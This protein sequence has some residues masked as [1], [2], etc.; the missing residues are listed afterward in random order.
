MKHLLRPYRSIALAIVAGAG[1]ALLPPGAP[2]QSNGFSQLLEKLDPLLSH[3]SS[4]GYLGVLVSDVDNDTAAKLKLKET[5]GALITLIDHDAP[6]GPV[7][8]I[9][10]VVLEINGQKVEG[11]EQFGRMLREIPAGRKVNLAFSRDG[12]QQTAEVQ[13]VDRKT[14][15]KAVWNSLNNPGATSSKAPAMG[16]LAGGGDLPSTGLRLSV[17]GSSLHVGAMVEPL[18]SQMADYLGIPNG[19]MIKQVARKSEA[20]AAGLKEHDV[21]LKVGTDAIT[22][23]ADWDR[24]LRASEGKQVPVTILRDR[25][26][27]TVMLQVDSKHKSEVE[28]EKAWPGLLPDGPAPLLAQVFGPDFGTDAAGILQSQDFQQELRID[29]RQMEQFRQDAEKLRDSMKSWNLPPIDQK[30]MDEFRKQMDQ[31][32]Q[33]F[34]ADDFKIDPKAMDELKKQMEQFRQS[35]KMDGFKIDPKQMEDFNRQMEEMRKSFPQGFPL[36][37]QQLEQFKQQMERMSY[38]LGQH[39]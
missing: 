9:N 22:T 12:A 3:S 39:V 17:F 23:T 38:G 16:I 31:F 6:A 25:K 13:L 20:A 24:A 10:D 36:N 28:F 7:L 19:V 18:T 27:Q 4:Q 21:I 34:S 15:E 14:M 26:Q 8:K 29:P 2:A 32:K 30:Q 35:F 33:G 37:K 5:R 11:A 1:L